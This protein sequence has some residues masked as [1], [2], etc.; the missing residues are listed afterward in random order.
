MGAFGS[1]DDPDVD[2]DA[3]FV[4]EPS[5]IFWDEEGNL[6]YGKSHPVNQE[7][8]I[9]EIMQLDHVDDDEVNYCLRTTY[10]D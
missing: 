8:Q 7:K 9:R 1:K 4:Y 3:K 2:K 10:V 6:R 5:K